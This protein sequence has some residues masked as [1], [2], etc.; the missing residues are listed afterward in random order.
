MNWIEVKASLSAPPEDWAPWI[1][2]FRGFGCENTLQSERPASL[3]GCVT[4]T[5]GAEAHVRRLKEALLAQGA[6]L[7]ET[8]I[9]A[10]ENWTELWKQYFTVR[11]VGERFVIHPTWEAYEPEAGDLVIALDPGQA[12]GTGDHPTTRMCLELLERADLAGRTVADVG[13]GSGILSVG[14]VRLGAAE[15]L[16]VDLDPIAVE[17]A[18]ANAAL[19]GVSFRCLVG[20]GLSELA[21]PDGQ[22]WDRIVSNIISAV[23]IGIAAQVPPLLAPGGLWIVS[24]II[25]ANWPL[26]EDAARSAGFTIREVLREDGWVSATLQR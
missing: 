25:E 23:L 1:E 12:F 11:R 2:T 13:C 26:V 3:T 5:P 19:N 14:A 24:G 18:Q 16:A 4:N 17:V 8:R 6:S 15:V 20:D 7:V 21:R 10:E 9:V 22:G